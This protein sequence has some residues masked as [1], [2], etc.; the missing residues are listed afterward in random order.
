MALKIVVTLILLTFLFSCGTGKSVTS[1][2]RE[3]AKSEL[4]DEFVIMAFSGPPPEE[5]TRER[6]QEIADA[7]IEILVP[8]NGIFNA[9]QNLKVM[10]LAEKVGIRVIPVDM[11][12]L[13]F[14]LK[15]GITI[16][17]S[18]I[19]DVVNDYKSHPALA[20]YVIKDEPG[21]DLFPALKVL[22]DLFLNEDPAHQP[23]INLFPSYASP[24]Q[25][26][27]DNYRSYI[28][29]YIKTVKPGL[30]SYDNYAL[31]EGA[32]LYSTWYSDLTMVREETRKANIPFMVFVQS[33]GIKGGLRVPD[34]AEILWQ[35]NTA[36]AYGARG[37]GWF[38]YWTPQ[39]DQGFPQEDGAMPP[40]IESH[41]N[42]MI[43]LNGK[44][45]EVYDFVR[46]A[47]LY[48]K[49]TG[50]GLLNW[51]NTNVARYEA[52]KVVEGGFSPLVSPSGEQANLVVGTYMKG[53]ISRIVLSN[54][55]CDESAAFSILISSKWK[56]RGFFASIN[57]SPAGD[58]A[59][60]LDWNLDPGG[61]VVIELQQK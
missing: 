29:S 26:G 55:H 56:I 45:T 19:K 50:K 52:G 12:V 25:L 61:S 23:L 58:K 46:E 6:L 35:I 4:T 5:V 40:I 24:V 49:K 59:S 53:K 36:L 37:F 30:L 48:L 18:I 8:G 27:F 60:L 41:Y 17:K 43:D 21:A 39:P 1:K 28:T 13:P 7:G 47:N 22:S 14:S 9:E 15:P 32:T 51:D 11:R 31:R 16:D 42:A 54:S 3:N 10:D 44:R 34:R 33:E 2:S 20:G 38:C 57:A